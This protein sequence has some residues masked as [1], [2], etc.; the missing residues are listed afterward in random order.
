MIF[1]SQCDKLFVFAD[2]NQNVCQSVTII[3]KD[4]GYQFSLKV[5]HSKILNVSENWQLHCLLTFSGDFCVTES[6]FTH[7][8][9]QKSKS[10]Q[11]CLN[12]LKRPR[13]PVCFLKSGTLGHFLY[14]IFVYSYKKVIPCSEYQR[15]MMLNVVLTSLL[16]SMWESIYTSFLSTELNINDTRCHDC[17]ELSLLS[18][19]IPNFNINVIDYKQFWVA[20][21][22]NEACYQC[23]D[24]W[25]V[26]V[27]KVVFALSN[28]LLFLRVYCSVVWSFCNWMNKVKHFTC[29]QH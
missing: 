16:S 7:T 10:E 27:T 22:V 8:F 12:D 11:K 25:V 20:L 1:A 13:V 2:K 26:L 19:S 17:I 24:V 6:S 4:P 14:F 5:T 29:T 9:R 21:C 23:D 3:R 18:Y 15:K 28:R